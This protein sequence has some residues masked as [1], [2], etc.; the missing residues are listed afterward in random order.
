MVRAWRCQ[1]FDL[2]QETG[3]VQTCI[4]LA[5][6]K[7]E[8]GKKEEEPEKEVEKQE[9]SKK[10]VEEVEVPAQDDNKNVQTK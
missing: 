9:E 7:G 10:E 4:S 5:P 8:V 2:A 6:S 1:R 3:P